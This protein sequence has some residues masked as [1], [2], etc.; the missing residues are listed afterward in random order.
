M[1]FSA[2]VEVGGDGWCTVWVGELLGF[3]L[4]EPSEK[5]AMARLPDGIRA[6]LRWLRRHGEQ[7]DAPRRIRLAVAEREVHRAAMRYGGYKALFSCD[8]PPVTKADIE[9]AIRWM[10]Y[11]RADLLGLVG[12]LAPGAMTWRRRPG[13]RT[14]E[15]HLRHIASA[16]RWYLQRFPC[17]WQRLARAVDPIERLHRMRQVVIPRLRALTAEERAQIVKPEHSWWSRRKMLGRFLYHER[18]HIRTIARIARERG[19]RV[20][21]GLGGW[22]TYS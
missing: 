22:H 9:K 18:Y 13:G 10:G 14:I 20:P 1:R 15:R 7:I 12:L 4:N 8:R 5:Q 6:Y 2:Y 17:R 21:E 16:E 11:M 19:V 3:F